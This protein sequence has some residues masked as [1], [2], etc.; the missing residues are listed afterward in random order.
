[1]ISLQRGSKLQTVQVELPTTLDDQG[2][3]SYAAKAPVDGRVIRGD[4]IARLPSGEE[5][6]TIATI[7]IDAAQSPLP[8]PDARLTCE[9]G[10]VGIVVER[11]DGRS[12]QGGALDHVRVRIRE[13]A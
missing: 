8:V 9:D 2:K 11:M 10:L 13:E 3:Q 6:K 5:I 7:W 1:M 12:L 4:D